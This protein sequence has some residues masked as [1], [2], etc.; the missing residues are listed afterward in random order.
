MIGL[1]DCVGPIGLAPVYQ[2]ER[3]AVRLR[4][5]VCER[6]QVI[7][8]VADDVEDGSV[9]GSL[10][11]PLLRYPLRLAVL[12]SKGQRRFLERQPLN[13]LFQLSRYDAPLAGIAPPLAGQRRQPKPPI[14]HDPPLGRAEWNT[15]VDRHR[16]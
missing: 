4:A 9:A 15:G 11:T 13:D 12:R 5:L 1:P 14:S 8:Q 3:F 6:D 16:A 2:L 10:F 7:G